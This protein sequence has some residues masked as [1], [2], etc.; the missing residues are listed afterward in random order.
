MQSC[1]ICTAHR[2]MAWFVL[3][4]KVCFYTSWP[5]YIGP[6]FVIAKKNLIVLY[7]FFVIPNRSLFFTFPAG[8]A[9][10][11]YRLH[12]L[13]MC[14][15]IFTA[16]GDKRFTAGSNIIPQEQITANLWFL[17]P[18]IHAGWH[19][20]RPSSMNHFGITFLIPFCV[21]HSIFPFLM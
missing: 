11:I 9:P 6:L 10:H 15:L 7:F 3:F 17:V 14:F 16:F 19:L 5:A 20:S 2:F 12:D 4:F 8:C 13:R 21:V 1:H 18:I